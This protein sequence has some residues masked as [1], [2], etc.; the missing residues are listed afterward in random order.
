MSDDGKPG[1]GNKIEFPC[2]VEL[3]LKAFIIVKPLN[4]R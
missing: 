1:K 2:G 3:S 4:A